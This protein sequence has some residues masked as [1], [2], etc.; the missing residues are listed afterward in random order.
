MSLGSPRA[1]YGNYWDHLNGDG[2]WD[3]SDWVWVVEFQRQDN[4]TVERVR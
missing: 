2:A 1:A 4:I 3:R